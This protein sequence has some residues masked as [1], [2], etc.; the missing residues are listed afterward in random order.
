MATAVDGSRDFCPLVMKMCICGDVY[1]WR[2]C[3]KYDGGR[4]K[5]GLM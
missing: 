4:K 2:A 3:G 5:P 1:V